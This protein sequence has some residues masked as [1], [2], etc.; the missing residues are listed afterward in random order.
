MGKSLIILVICVQLITQIINFF[1]TTMADVYGQEKHSLLI[2]SGLKSGQLK[3]HCKAFGTIVEKDVEHVIEPGKSFGWDFVVKVPCLGNINYY[4]CNFDW[5]GKKVDFN[6]WGGAWESCT[7]K[8]TKTH[9]AVL[10]DGFYYRCVG[11]ERKWDKRFSWEALINLG[12]SV[13]SVH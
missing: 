12:P 5:N 2:S 10:E 9:W 13:E 11:G 7:G 4:S 3:V 8:M 1:P 6:A